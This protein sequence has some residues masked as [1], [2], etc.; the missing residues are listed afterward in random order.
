MTTTKA[1]LP[2]HALG[3][4]AL[5]LEGAANPETAVEI[6]QRICGHVKRL[7]DHPGLHRAHRDPD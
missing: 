1:V 2:E 3:A 5:A 6:I 7:G 4:I